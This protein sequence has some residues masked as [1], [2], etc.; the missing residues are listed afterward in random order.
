[1]D[2]VLQICSRDGFVLV[3]NEDAR[4]L[5][6]LLVFDAPSDGTFI[7]RTFAFPSQPNSTIAFAGAENYVYRLTVTT[8]A[9]LDHTLPLSLRADEPTEVRLFGW[10][11]AD[12]AGQTIAPRAAGEF[13]AV[14]HPEAAGTLRLPVLS[15]PNLVAGDESS[16]AAPQSVEWPVVVSGRIESPGDTDAFRIRAAKGQKLSARIESR[17]FGFPLDAVLQI[18]D[19]AGAVLAEVDD[20]SSER[21]PVLN[22]TIPADAEYDVRVRDLHD[23]G[24]LRY[25]Y[26][27]TIGEP[28]PGFEL[29]LANDAFVLKPGEPLEIPVTILRQNGFAEDVEIM[30]AD[31]PPGVSAEPAISLGKGDSAKGVKLILGSTG[32][33]AS[34]AFRVV[35]RVTE[36]QSITRYARFPIKDVGATHDRAWLTVLTATDTPRE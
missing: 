36:P 1:M 22:Y 31:L 16:P 3:Q 13:A 12:A 14:F 30:A 5:D 8:G 9:V 4:G 15:L 18:A 35:G 29:T 23:R 21:D 32:T 17:A 11:L 27:L 33:S 19:V 24:G 7:V 34:G 20:V 25:V 10:N 2:A 26:R 28:T 6:P